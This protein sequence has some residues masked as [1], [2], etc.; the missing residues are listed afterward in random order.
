MSDYLISLFYVADCH[1]SGEGLQLH[2]STLVG[3]TLL[4]RNVTMICTYME[5]GVTFF[6]WGG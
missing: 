2:M 3:V 5:V 1:S 4:L 6:C